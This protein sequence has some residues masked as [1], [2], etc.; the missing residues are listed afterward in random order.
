MFGRINNFSLRGF[1]K[2]EETADEK[3]QKIQLK[4]D[5]I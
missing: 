1:L 5:Y 4:K 3:V 2:T